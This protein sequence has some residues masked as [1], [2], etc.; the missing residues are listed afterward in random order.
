MP[1]L[2][3]ALLALSY[4]VFS[5]L[6]GEA[7]PRQDLRDTLSQMKPL[8]IFRRPAST[9]EYKQRSKGAYHLIPLLRQLENH[10]VSHF[11][12]YTKL[13]LT[14]CQSPDA[15]K[16]L[17]TYFDQ[18][19]ELFL[20][21]GYWRSRIFSKDDTDDGLPTL[22]SVSDTL[23]DD[24]DYDSDAVYDFEDSEYDSE[25]SENGSE[26]IYMVSK[27]IPLSTSPAWDEINASLDIRLTGSDSL[28]GFCDEAH[29]AR[30]RLKR[31]LF[32]LLKGSTQSKAA[33]FCLKQIQSED[34]TE[35]LRIAFA[36]L[37]PHSLL[38]AWK[39]P[40]LRTAIQCLQTQHLIYQ[41]L[42][43]E[44]RKAITDY[45][46]YLLTPDQRI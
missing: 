27:L 35:D 39:L 23:E 29:F 40:E 45:L 17:V 3:D 33:L 13:M 46:N 30:S 2:I 21:F 4:H 44:T 41:R 16:N 1:S 14:S 38:H 43:V 6:L 5:R 20:P 15:Y 31:T 11:L 26:D 7:T 37:L 36:K 32:A 8:S 18:Q 9:R 22:H 12:L 19:F 34:I 28:K 42:P 25:D 10:I 24:S